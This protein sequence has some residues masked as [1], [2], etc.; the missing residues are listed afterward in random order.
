[1]RNFKIG[2]SLGPLL[3]IKEIILIARYADEAGGVDS[4]WIPESWGRESFST[5]G[6]ISQVTRKLRLGQ[7]DNKRIFQNPG[8]HSHGCSNPRQ[9]FEQQDNNWARNKYTRVSY[10][11]AWH[12]I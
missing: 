4:I 1:M 2:F 3:S 7:L 8:N 11:L 9:T 12:G 10:R 5:L 6:A